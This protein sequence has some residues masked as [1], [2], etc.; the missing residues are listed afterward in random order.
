MHFG[1]TLRLLRIDAGRSLRALAQR[2][3]VSSAYLSRVEHGVDSVP[4]PERLADIARALGL[5]PTLLLELAH[6]VGPFVS[7]YLESVPAANVVFLDMARRN[8]TGTQLARVKAFIDAEFPRTTPEAGDSAASLRALISPDRII[9][10]FIGSDITDVIDIAASRLVPAS[11]GL[12][13]SA[14]ASRIRERESEASTALGGGVAVPHAIIAGCSMA[15]ALVTLARPL[16]APT[17]DGAP[18][19]LLVVLISPEGGRR[20]L[21][22]LAQVARLASH[23]VAEELCKTRDLAELRAV[24]AQLEA[25]WR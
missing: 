12:S 4:T 20:Y 25:L 21:K 15:A 16:D 24:L 2:V 14:L 13:A 23:D 3:G 9:R 11:S 7:R 17:P 1:V 10:D 19:R 18:L 6:Q 22:A 5:S 8:L